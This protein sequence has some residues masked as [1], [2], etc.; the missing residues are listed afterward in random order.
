MSPQSID[1]WQALKSHTSFATVAQ[2]CC[3]S[4]GLAD[5]AAEVSREVPEVTRRYSFGGPIVGYQRYEV[6]QDNTF[7]SSV[8][9]PRGSEMLY[10]SGTTGRPKGIKLPL[11]ELSV[12]EPGGDVIASLLQHAFGVTSSDVYLSPAP[13]YHAAPLRWAAAIHAIGGTVV[14]ME[15]FE[16]EAALEAIERLQVTLRRWCRRCS[17]EC[18]NCPHRPANA[19]TIRR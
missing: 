1:T 12:D 19:T 18:S 17:C 15:K 13:I 9:Q 14:L 11:P 3:C 5:L 8:E 10:S 2:A 4:A 7:P 6:L 16:A